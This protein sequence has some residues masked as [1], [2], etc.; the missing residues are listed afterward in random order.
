MWDLGGV[1]L[2]QSK[3]PAVAFAR[4][5]Q[6]LRSD[7][8]DHWYLSYAKVGSARTS[9]AGRDNFSC[10]GSLYLGS[11]LGQFEGET[12]R[13]EAV[14]LYIPRDFCRDAAGTL[15]SVSNTNLTTG[16]GRLLADYLLDVERRISMLTVDELPGLLA[17]TRTMIMACV[18]PNADRLSE[19]QK[20]IDA[21]ILERARQMIQKNLLSPTLGADELCRALGVSRSRLYRLFEPMGGVVHYIRCRRLLDAHAAL[22]DASDDRRITDIA[23]ERGFYDAAEFSRAF[24]REFGYRPR[25][26][27]GEPIRRQPPA[28]G[29]KEK[30]GSAVFGDVLRR[31]QYHSS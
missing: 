10:A 23:A 3:F 19:A 30:G 2:L 22:C 17:A 20:P 6:N 14:Y 15:D 4:T 8:V 18:G 5:P 28:N 25:D 27:R 12:S 1:A 21:T 24:K 7:P 11:L 26:A 13:M 31:L 29:M 16:L 9:A